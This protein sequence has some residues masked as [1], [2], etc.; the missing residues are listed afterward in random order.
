MSTDDLMCIALCKHWH[1]VTLELMS[2][3]HQLMTDNAMSLQMR[4]VLTSHEVTQLH[5][6]VDRLTLDALVIVAWLGHS[7]T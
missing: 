6:V 3:A 7:A 5:T 2:L 4:W 1:D